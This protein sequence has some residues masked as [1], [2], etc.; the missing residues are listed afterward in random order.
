M[1]LRARKRLGQ[2]F[3]HDPAVIERIVATIAPRADDVM[4]EIGGGRGALTVPLHRIVRTLHVVELDERMAEHLTELC[5]D[6]GRLIMHRADALRF[7]FASLAR[8]P[9]SLRI[10]GNLPYNI[11][12]PLL[13]HLLNQRAAIKDMHL[14]LQKEVARRMTASPGGKEYG[15][16]TVTLALWAETKKCFD[17][18]PGAFHPAPKIWS[19]LVRI[20]PQIEPRF[21]VDSEARFAQLVARTFSMR[22][23]T[24]ARALKGDLSREDIAAAGIDPTA[25]AE[26]L[27][28]EDFARLANIRCASWA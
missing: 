20:T 1:Q 27:S 28:P 8:Q 16:L 12:T 10:V 18:G 11:S 22:R 2:H 19:T 26:T 14:M 7:D 13:F 15:R 4:A 9:G 24:L 3:L 5:P 21:P 25:R 6:A 17:I 23:K